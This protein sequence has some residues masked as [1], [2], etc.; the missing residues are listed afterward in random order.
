VALIVGVLLVTG[1]CSD[2]DDEGGFSFGGGEGTE[3]SVPGPSADDGGGFGDLGGGEDTGDLGGGD[4]GGDAFGGES[5]STFVANCANFPGASE[6][7]C[8]CAWGEIS[9]SVSASEYAAFEE[10]FLS[11]PNTSLPDWLTDA[12]ASCS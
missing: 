4:S 7:L 12:V 2:D 5:M 6:S 3:G 8:E 1:A 11:D 10:E 9:G